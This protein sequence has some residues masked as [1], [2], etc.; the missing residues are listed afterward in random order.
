MCGMATTEGEINVGS[1]DYQRGNVYRIKVQ[2]EMYQRIERRETR[3]K[4]GKNGKVKHHVVY[5]YHDKWV[6]HP[7]DSSRFHRVSE[8]DKNPDVRWPVTSQQFKARD[9]KLGAYHIPDDMCD[10][11][12][13][14]NIREDWDGEDGETKK[15]KTVAHLDKQ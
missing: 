9:V 15:V 6:S 1:L 10:M 2:A 11:L 8:R 5:T 3:K 4:K 12:G 13:N 14:R 7:V